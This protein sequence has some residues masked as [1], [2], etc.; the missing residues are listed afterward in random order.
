MKSKITLDEA[1]CKCLNQWDKVARDIRNGSTESVSD[2]KF[3]YMAEGGESCMFCAYNEEQKAAGCQHCPGHLVDPA[4]H[5]M[6][7]K[8]DYRFHPILFH[9]KLIEL[10]GKRLRWWEKI[11]WAVRMRWC[12]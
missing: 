1:W 12:D 3:K 6:G 10:N 9:A 4:F 8:Y 11:L 5:C 7:T 2:L